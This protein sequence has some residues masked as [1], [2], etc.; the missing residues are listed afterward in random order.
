MPGVASADMTMSGKWRYA[1]PSV[2]YAAERFLRPHGYL[3]AKEKT[4]HG[5]NREVGRSCL[6]GAYRLQ[7]VDPIRGIPPLHGGGEESRTARRNPSSLAC[8]DLGQGQG[9][10]FRD[11]RA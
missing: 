1:A 10:G 5:K 7:P 11:H 8:G 9:V 3:P 4:T 6:P 2:R